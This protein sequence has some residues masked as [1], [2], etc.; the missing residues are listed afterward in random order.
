M[1]TGA[2]GTFSGS[3]NASVTFAD[4]GL[5]TPTTGSVAISLNMTNA[6]AT[7]TYSSSAGSQQYVI[8]IIGT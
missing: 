2:S 8:S 7:G 1:N 3:P 4:P 5:V 6:T